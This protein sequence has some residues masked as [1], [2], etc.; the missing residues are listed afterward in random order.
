[1]GMVYKIHTGDYKI[2]LVVEDLET[3]KKVAGLPLVSAVYIGDQQMAEKRFDL[4]RIDMLNRHQNRFSVD[5]EF[6]DQQGQTFRITVDLADPFQ[7]ALYSDSVYNVY[8]PMTNTYTRCEGIQAACDAMYNAA[9]D[10]LRD[11]NMHVY[12]IHNDES[13]V[14]ALA[15][16]NDT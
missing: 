10:F 9:Q 11:L 16:F 3:A 5:R 2:E 13:I 14:S 4:H 15:P 7:E 6:T 8:D 1:M 12:V